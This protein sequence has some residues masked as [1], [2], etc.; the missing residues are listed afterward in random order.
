MAIVEV[1]QSPPNI[2]SN[3]AFRYALLVSF[4]LFIIGSCYCSFALRLRRRGA[5]ANGLFISL[6]ERS[7]TNIPEHPPELMEAWVYGKGKPVW[8][9]MKVRRTLSIVNASHHIVNSVI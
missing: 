6:A 9:E 2:W 7:R 5:I 1:D 3:D 8:S 4:L